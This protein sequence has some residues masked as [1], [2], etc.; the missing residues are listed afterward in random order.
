MLNGV[1]GTK[2]GT[3]VI[4]SRETPCYLCE[5][6]PCVDVCPSDALRQVKTNKDV[7]MGIAKIDKDT[8]FAFNGILCRACFE[9]C[10][11]YREGIVMENQLYPKVQEEYCVGC[12]ICENVCPT[13][14]GSIFVESRHPIVV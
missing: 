9:R 8:C 3:P 4:I 2:M 11:I 10:P 5:D 14:N 6:F 13:E 1:H 12:G 7:K